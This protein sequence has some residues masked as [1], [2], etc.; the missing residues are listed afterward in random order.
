M[1]LGYVCDEPG[2]DTFTPSTPIALFEH[3]VEW[4]DDDGVGTRRERLS[5]HFC[6]SCA[7]NMSVRLGIIPTVTED[8]AL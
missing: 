7:H 8:G 1:T 6:D 5:A 3:T 4:V 2:C